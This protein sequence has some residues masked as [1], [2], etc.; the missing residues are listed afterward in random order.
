M[1]LESVCLEDDDKVTASAD[2][3]V[4]TELV[5]GL[6]GRETPDDVQRVG[7]ELQN[8]AS[9]CEESTLDSNDGMCCSFYVHCLA[10]S[11]GTPAD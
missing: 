5:R 9:L 4:Y 3:E 2:K 1:S 11:S 10:S 8:P 7:K 6:G